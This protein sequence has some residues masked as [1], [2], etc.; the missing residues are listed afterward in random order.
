[1]DSIASISYDEDNVVRLVLAVQ[2]KDV[3]THKVVT[4]YP[5]ARVVLT[6]QALLVLSEKTKQMVKYLGEREII[7]KVSLPPPSPGN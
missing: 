1:M 7:R 3:E 4:Q 2:R 5:V 6:L